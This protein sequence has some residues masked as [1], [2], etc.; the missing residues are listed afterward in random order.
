MLVLKDAGLVILESPKTGSQA[1]RAMLGRKA[2]IAWGGSSRHTSAASYAQNHA[3]ALAAEIGR[4]AETV[5]VVREPVDRLASWH[6][7]LHR[8]RV[9]DTERGAAGMSFDAFV[10]AVIS[11]DPPLFARVGRHDRFVGWDGTQAGVDHLFDYQRLDLLLDFLADR[12]VRFGIM[13]ERNVSPAIVQG[14][15]S[16]STLERLQRANA[17]EF[18][19]YA[20][21]SARGHLRRPGAADRGR[22]SGGGDAA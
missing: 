2:D 1:L 14:P 4:D 3:A 5:A 13:K 17:A 22:G 21:V 7:F 12:G 20:A 16:V 19:M 10:Q 6:R 8:E 18:A 15:L 11:P 9:A